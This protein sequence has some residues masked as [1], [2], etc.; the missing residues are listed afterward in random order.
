MFMCIKAWNVTAGVILM[1]SMMKRT[2]LLFILCSCVQAHS[3]VKRQ[4]GGAGP[5]IREIVPGVHSFTSNGQYMSMIIIDPEGVMVIEP[6]NVKHSQQMLA[7]VRN[8]TEA[9]IKY[10]FYSHN[11]YDHAKG[12]QVW[13]DEGATIVSHIDAFDYIEANPSD[14]LVLPDMKWTGDFFTVTVGNMKL[15]LYYFGLSHGNGMTAFRLPNQKVGY[16]ADFMTPN[17]VFFSYLPDFNIPGLANT[18]EQYSKLDVDLIVTSHSGKEDP[19]DPATQEDTKASLQY[20][21]VF[22]S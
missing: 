14:D 15:E 5:R 12:G 13:K 10:L 3:I 4:E 2:S 20:L 8:L 17:R 22:M 9:P 21:K 11:H 7:V 16:I 18:L 1:I 19:L 6:V